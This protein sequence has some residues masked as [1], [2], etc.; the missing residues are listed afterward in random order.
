MN[1]PGFLSDCRV[2]EK[3]QHPELFSATGVDLIKQEF[4]KWSKTRIKLNSVKASAA[5]WIHD[6][7]SSESIN[8]CDFWQPTRQEVNTW[9]LFSVT[10]SICFVLWED[11]FYRPALLIRLS[12]FGSDPQS[13]FPLHVTFGWC[14]VT[15]VRARGVAGTR[16]S[17]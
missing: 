17:T 9:R 8:Q 14:M 2:M 16:A 3:G 10:A 11:S 1:C 13:A 6:C 12:H 5:G 4:W 7:G 15:G